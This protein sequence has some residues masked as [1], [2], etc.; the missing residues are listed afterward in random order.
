MRTNGPST[1]PCLLQISRANSIKLLM[2]TTRA[3]TS[4]RKRWL[5]RLSSNVQITLLRC[6]TLGF[7]AKIAGMLLAVNPNDNQGVRYI[8]PK[9]WFETNNEAAI[10]E[11]CQLWQGDDGPDILYSKAL[12]FSIEK[13]MSEARA[14]VQ[15][16]VAARP[17]V[18][19]EL[20]QEKHIEPERRFPDAIALGGADE[21]WEYWRAYGRYWCKSKLAMDLLRQATEMEGSTN[22]S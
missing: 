16:C 8:L 10:I 2:H 18:A 20:L 5:G 15:E 1:T 19:R 21:A 6:I 22:P 13:R 11:H 12:A 9:C 3:G 17:L 14:A 7:T 4:V